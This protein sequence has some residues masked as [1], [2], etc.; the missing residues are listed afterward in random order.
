MDQEPIKLR[1]RKIEKSDILDLTGYEKELKV[2]DD[3]YE[4]KKDEVRTV[5][6]RTQQIRE[7]RQVYQEFKSSRSPRVFD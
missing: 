2:L 7:P 1:T 5:H 4:L 3:R 6:Q